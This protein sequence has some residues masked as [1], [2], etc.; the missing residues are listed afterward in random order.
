MERDAWVLL[1][2]SSSLVTRF[3]QGVFVEWFKGAR[4][5]VLRFL[6][7]G[8]VLQG[9]SSLWVFASP[10][11]LLQSEGEIQNDDR[12]GWARVEL[13]QEMMMSSR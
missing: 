3:G 6:K 13:R 11:P 10:S 12:D 2:P 1:G 9:E 5:R 7:Q 4:S 8:Q